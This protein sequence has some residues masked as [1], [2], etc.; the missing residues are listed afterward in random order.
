MALSFPDAYTTP[1]SID[2]LQVK[3][4]GVYCKAHEK[5]KA[6]THK[7]GLLFHIPSPLTVYCGVSHAALFS[8]TE[9]G[10]KLVSLYLP[11][12]S[13]HYAVYEQDYEAVFIE[14]PKEIL[15]SKKPKWKTEIQQ[16]QYATHCSV[17][18]SQS[19]VLLAA[20]CHRFVI[21]QTPLRI[22]Y[23]NDIQ[24]ISELPKH[25]YHLMPHQE[26]SFTIEAPTSFYVLQFC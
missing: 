3:V 2:A 13:L 4:V 17:S 22:S 7:G 18:L 19:N 25:L 9:K 8:S 26:Y 16:E 5:E 15:K 6:H 10:D 11:P 21:S 14:I 20:K 12:A 23:R 1:Y 24:E